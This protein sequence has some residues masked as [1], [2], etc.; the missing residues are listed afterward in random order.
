[1]ERVRTA[2]ARS[3]LSGGFWKEAARFL[4]RLRRSGRHLTR[5]AADA[6][7]LAQEVLIRAVAKQ[8]TLR[9]PEKLEGWLLAI[10]KTVHLNA[11]R[12]LARRFEVLDG[13]LSRAAREPT[14]DLEQELTSRSL[15][16]ALQHALEQL[17]EAWAEAL[18][19]REV[20]ELSYQEIARAQKCPVGTVRSRLARARAAMADQLGRGGGHAGLRRTVE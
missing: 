16:D 12:G 19:L 7:D 14:G 17:P 6:E 20:E 5:N 2:E 15:E 18:W 3:V 8:H 9:D 10:Q 1:M 13:G 11:Q 4:P